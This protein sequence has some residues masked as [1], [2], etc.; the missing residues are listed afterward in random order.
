MKKKG[1]LVLIVLL[2]GIGVYGGIYFYSRY[3]TKVA[4]AAD[5]ETSPKGWKKFSNQVV[6]FI[7]PADWN[8]TTRELRERPHGFA[9]NVIPSD[10]RKPGGSIAFHLRSDL[11]GTAIADFAAD[12]ARVERVYREAVRVQITNR[13][14]LAKDG[15]GSVRFDVEPFEQDSKSY[16]GS[17]QLLDAKEYRVVAAIHGSERSV[18]ETAHRI[19]NSLKLFQ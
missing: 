6:E 2:V 13:Q 5:T 10:P 9:V 1:F 11:A 3:R 14:N 17:I 7:Y 18:I 16:Y 4:P 8:I 15:R 12:V 19:Y